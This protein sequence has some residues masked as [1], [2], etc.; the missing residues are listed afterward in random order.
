MLYG[1]SPQSCETPDSPVA[2]CTVWPSPILG[3]KL[4]TETPGGF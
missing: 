2:A 1:R 3:H 4:I